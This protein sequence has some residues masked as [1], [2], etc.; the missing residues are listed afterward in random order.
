MPPPRAGAFWG[1]RVEGRGVGA[2][3]AGAARR[4]P[5][6]RPGGREP[7]W[8]GGSRGSGGG[9][10]QGLPALALAAPPASGVWEEEPR[11]S[12]SSGRRRSPSR[13]WEGGE[14]RLPG[15]N[16]RSEGEPTGPPPFYP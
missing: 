16:Y 2:L 8:G 6:L 1:W 14:P 4:G 12:R 11:S 7:G 5:R 9:D 13:G 3:A 15:E 10:S